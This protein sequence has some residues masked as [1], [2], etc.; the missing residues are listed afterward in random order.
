M[1][2]W[3]I[4]TFLSNRFKTFEVEPQAGSFNAVMEK[5]QAAQKK[6]R[7]RALA[8]WFV[9]LIGLFTLLFNYTSLFT[10]SLPISENTKPRLS[11]PADSKL[12]TTNER[13]E[14]THSQKISSGI[15]VQNQNTINKQP[16]VA[17]LVKTSKIPGIES[18]K[19][20]L[21]VYSK[22]AKKV[23]H[24]GNPNKFV[25]SLDL[26]SNL[27]GS[28]TKKGNLTGLITKKPS[29][30]E[31]L[32][33]EK[34]TT[35]FTI[36]QNP[37]EIPTIQTYSSNRFDE[38]V[39]VE[40]V[41]LLNPVKII[42]TQKEEEL[43]NSA[44]SIKITEKELLI[45]KSAKFHTQFYAGLSYQP[46]FYS[47]NYEVNTG[48]N[49]LPKYYPA[50][51]SDEY[52]Q[53]LKDTKKYN[54]TGVPGIKMGI[55]F[56]KKFEL[57]ATVGFYKH[58]SEEK[59]KIPTF[60]TNTVISNSI[61]PFQQPPLGG[62]PNPIT[63]SAK[64]NLD[65][66][67]YKNEYKQ[68]YISFDASAILKTRGFKFKPGISFVINQI[69]KGSFVFVDNAGYQY[70]SND[71]KQFNKSVYGLSFKA[72]LNRTL[73]RNLELQISPVYNLSLSSIFKHNYF[74]TQK[75]YGFGIEG[76]LIYKFRFNN[77]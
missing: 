2:N 29:E 9:G 22:S 67:T 34:D 27:P 70:L 6:K 3:N 23:P 12:H 30:E 77:K 10:S 61:T 25:S 16:A 58:S 64:V 59:I 74:I 57:G 72:G 68:I 11:R 51:F 56:R 69:Q 7:R 52:V 24:V 8:F 38:Y 26:V 42:N 41:L 44:N 60:D 53:N 33:A 19:S 76:V 39:V 73:A 28:V 47:Y 4:N 43:L 46:T 71:K 13:N 54:M 1:A 35:N 66:N 45:L 75:L 40:N 18:K 15:H 48:N 5:L 49:Q 21:T 62:S 36:N 65:N 32:N 50:N 37:K 14:R 31:T 63:G 17:N 55:T 20:N